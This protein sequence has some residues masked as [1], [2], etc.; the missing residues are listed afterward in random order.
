MTQRR[1]RIWLSFALI[2][3]L[4]LAGDFV[5]FHAQIERQE[6]PPARPAAAMIAL[7]G[8]AARVSDAIDL[9]EQ[10]YA[11]RMLISGVNPTLTRA[12]VIRMAPRHKTLIECCVDLGYDALDTVGNAREARRWMAAHELRGPLIIVTSNYHMPRALVEMARAM[13]GMGFLPVPVISERWRDATL[14]RDPAF[15][16]LLAVEYVKFLAAR[17]RSLLEGAFSSGSA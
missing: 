9:L 3:A 4:G 12:D 17:T 13:P 11:G 15:A 2:V 16:R 14:W 10:G 8:G 7:T 6:H 5:R 1:W